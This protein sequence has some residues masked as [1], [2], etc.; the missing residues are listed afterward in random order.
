MAKP[1]I[2]VVG[3]G[4]GGLEPMRALGLKL[5]KTGRAN[6]TLVEKES[7]HIWKP[8][9]H[10]VASGALD[11]DKD[12][13]G[14]LSHA[15]RFG[16]SFV[17][18]PMTGID[19]AARTITVAPPKTPDGETLG[20]ALALPYD[21]AT[22]DF[23]TPGVKAHEF[24]N[25]LDGLETNEANRLV[26]KPT[27]QTTEDERIFAFGDCAGLPMGD[28][29]V[30]MRAQAAHQMAA[31][32]AK[33]LERAIGGAPLEAFVYKDHGSLVSLRARSAVGALFGGDVVIDGVGA[34]LAYNSLYRM[35][36]T[37]VNGL[38]RGLWRIALGKL[39]GAGASRLKLHD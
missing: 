35:H 36:R 24:L 12:E 25:E 17:H 10:E 20:E 19:R 8:L 16:Y 30:P 34:R 15:R 33:N 9:L 7:T 26:A 13:I 18:G 2:V 32:V 31:H 27:L 14:Y 38:G 5:A 11:A 39:Q 37:G 22:N 21:C 1:E 28:A 4:A 29:W 23:G 6:V 3:G